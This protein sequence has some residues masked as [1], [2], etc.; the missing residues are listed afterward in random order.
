MQVLR[1]IKPYWFYLICEGIKVNEIG[2]TE[3]KSPDWDRKVFLYCSKDMVSFRRIPK[4]FQEKYRPYLS[5][6]GAEFICDSTVD[7]GK[8]Y[9]YAH[10]DNAFYEILRGA[11]LTDRDLHNYAPN[12][13]AIALHISELAVFDKPKDVG[14][15]KKPC[16]SPKYPYCPSCEVGYEYISESEE[17]AYR[18]FGECSTEWVCLNR[19]KRAPQSWCYVEGYECEE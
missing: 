15:F 2:K 18:A 16:I 3:P 8:R 5:K 4:E 11:C 19:V 10:K 7:L 12:G 6:V 9:A 17:E 1:S 13:T 14:S